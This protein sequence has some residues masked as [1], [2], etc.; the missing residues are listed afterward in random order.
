M[1]FSNREKPSPLNR[2]SIV[3]Y[4]AA[5]VALCLPGSQL[6]VQTIDAGVLS[7]LCKMNR[8][9]ACYENW[10]EPI[11]KRKADSKLLVIGL[12]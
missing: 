1:I 4:R 2:V 11:R 3:C 12:I 8:K 9:N 10:P 5:L 7:L 6:P